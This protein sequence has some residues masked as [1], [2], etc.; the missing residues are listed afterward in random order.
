MREE[1][2]KMTDENKIKEK[3]DEIFRLLT[4]H[5]TNYYKERPHKTSLAAKDFECLEC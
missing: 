4:N 2:S 5:K 1:T 3:K